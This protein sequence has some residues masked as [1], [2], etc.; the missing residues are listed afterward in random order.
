[1]NPMPSLQVRNYIYGSLRQERSE[2][3]FCL[4]K[5][6]KSISGMVF[7]LSLGKCVTKSYKGKKKPE[8]LTW[9]PGGRVGLGQTQPGG[10]GEPRWTLVHREGCS[11]VTSGIHSASAQTDVLLPLRQRQCSR[12]DRCSAPAQ[13]D[14]DSWGSQLC[15]PTEV[16]ATGVGEYQRDAKGK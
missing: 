9:K 16:G 6:L 15:Q 14:A 13:T 4:F 7:S 10:Q 12:S 8:I 3:P 1:M 5:L 11:H 2:L